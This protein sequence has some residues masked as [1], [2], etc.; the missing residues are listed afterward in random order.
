MPEFD[1]FGGI[2]FS[3]AKEPLS[4]LWSAVGV[5]RAG[6]LHILALCP[7]PFRTDLANYVA[8]GWRKQLGSDTGKILWGAD[9]PF[10]IPA[11]AAAQIGEAEAAG[12]NQLA[13]WIADRP[14]DE[15]RG[16]LP[17]H[18]RTPRLTDA[19]GAMAPLDLRIFKQTV[20][21]IR[22]L[23]EL[24]ETAAVSIHPQA[25]SP[26]ARTTLVEVYPS[27]TATDLGLRCRRTPSRPGEVRA[28]PAALRTFLS[29]D[30]SSMEATAVALEDAWD[31]CLAC[32]TAWL[33]RG[34]LDQPNRIRPGAQQQVGLEGWIFRPPAAVGG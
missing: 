26:D 3:G 31:A 10:G 19:G 29:F 21:G 17:E 33:A 13:A 23:H 1:F 12:W 30:H 22:W 15:V 28:R 9:F 18:A 14:A 7:H 8:D 20:E 32:L 4:N 6:K 24:R 2:D 16:T 27:A 5:E 25:P 11:A 34:D